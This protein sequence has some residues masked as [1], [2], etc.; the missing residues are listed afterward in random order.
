MSVLHKNTQLKQS[1]AKS[2]SFNFVEDFA[3]VS[4][5]LE[6]CITQPVTKKTTKKE[7]HHPLVVVLE[8]E[9]AAPAVNHV[10]GSRT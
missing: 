4:R 5:I 8:T 3:E 2:F 10:R 7:E 6:R 9:S 1:N